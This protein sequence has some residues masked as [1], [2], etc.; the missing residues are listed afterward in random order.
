MEQPESE[1]KVSAEQ[2]SQATTPVTGHQPA[3]PSAPVQVPT[4]PSA[5]E[6]AAGVIKEELLL[7]GLLVLLVGLVST[8]A[9]YGTFGVRYQSL[10]LPPTHF[11][12]RGLT[13]VVEQPL[14][15]LPY[16]ASLGIVAFFGVGSSKKSTLRK[17]LAYISILVIIAAS[18]W[19]AFWTGYL[20]ARRDMYDKTSMLPRIVALDGLNVSV[21][22]ELRIANEQTRL[23]FSG[24]DF[25]V[26]F[27]PHSDAE[28]ATPGR[29]DDFRPILFWVSNDTIKILQTTYP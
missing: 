27:T 1:I 7:I 15:L 20:S 2:A 6:V 16:V 9:Y 10:D 18:G 28:N 13:T 21:A 8:R 4:E 17:L 25:M 19:L 22:Q 14:L 5:K 26:V 29:E 11:I 3:P 12:I 23:L 24:D